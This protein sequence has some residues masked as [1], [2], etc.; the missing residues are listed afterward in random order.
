[1]SFRPLLFS[2]ELNVYLVCMYV[3]MY[4]C[5]HVSVCMI[6]GYLFVCVCMFCD[7]HV[8]MYVCMYT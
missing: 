3:C 7:M 2:G 6:V 5:M 1:M 4:G 8:C